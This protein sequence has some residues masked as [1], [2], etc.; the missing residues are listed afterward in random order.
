M[1]PIPASKIAQF[2]LGNCL[3]APAMICI[4]WKVLQ[5]PCVI[6]YQ[7]NNNFHYFSLV[8]TSTSNRSTAS[9]PCTRPSRTWLHR[10][11]SS[12][13]PRTR[14]VIE[15]GPGLSHPEYKGPP[16]KQSGGRESN[17][18]GGLEY[19]QSRIFCCIDMQISGSIPP[20]MKIV[21]CAFVVL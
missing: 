12:R 11:S 15:L 4:V 18:G 1:G 10:L 16:G 17:V 9:R 5:V 14:Q 8:G 19:Y 3:S 6:S 13:S 7:I 20:R 2:H 21:M